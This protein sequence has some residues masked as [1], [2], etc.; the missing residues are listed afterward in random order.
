MANQESALQVELPPGLL[1]L[2][3]RALSHR[4]PICIPEKASQVLGFAEPLRPRCKAFP[5]TMPKASSPPT[6]DLRSAKSNMNDEP[7]APLSPSTL[8]P[9]SLKSPR[10]PPGSPYQKGSTIRTVIGEN[11]MQVED[12][13][14]NG[15]NSHTTE[16]D[17]DD[18]PQSPTIT[19]IPQYPP[20]PK[21]S[22]RH[23]RDPSK[24]FF[25]NLK[26][27]KSSHRL[28]SPDGIPKEVT[29]KN[30]KNRT[31]SKDRTI[32]ASSR[33]RGSTPDLLGLTARSEKTNGVSSI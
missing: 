26:A 33:A 29:D 18:F 16:K 10:S 3:L 17:T 2:L 28:Q 11:K 27:S 23:G 25:G 31:S 5:S 22:S 12:S 8:S 24:S 13:H 15:S 30:S 1:P 4:S 32:Y 21:G 7:R 19:A 6:L 9:T 20:S 14:A